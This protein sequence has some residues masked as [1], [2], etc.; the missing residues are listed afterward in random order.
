VRFNKN[1]YDLNRNWDTVDPAKMP[2]ITL[3]RKAVFDWLD[4]GHSID[5]FLTMHNTESGEYLEAVD[6]RQLFQRVFQLLRD[7]TSFNPTSPLRVTASTTSPG[8]AGRKTV[9]QGLW[10]DR[11]V[12]GMLMEQMVEHNAKLGHMPTI[13]DRRRFGAELIRSLY[14]AVANQ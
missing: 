10:K 4:E 6:D 11:E 1:G 9:I 5:L 8:K 12:P 2:E 7:T 3:Q 13:E 14:Q